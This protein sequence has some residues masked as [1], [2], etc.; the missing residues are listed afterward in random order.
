MF[1]VAVMTSD[2]SDK[3]YNSTRFFLFTYLTFDAT[4][5]TDDVRRRLTPYLPVTYLMFDV[6]V[7]TSNKDNYSTRFPF[8]YLMFD[9]TAMTSD[10]AADDRYALSDLVTWLGGACALTIRTIR[11]WL[12]NVHQSNIAR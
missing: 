10:E 4:D 12:S 11:R 2:H 8:T 7:K 1:D 5:V 3:D 9:V 6:T